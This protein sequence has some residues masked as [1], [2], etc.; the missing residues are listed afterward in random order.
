MKSDYEFRA[1]KS[2]M[3]SGSGR[4]R[5][6]VAVGHEGRKG[7]LSVVARVPLS[8]ASCISRKPWRNADPKQPA[9]YLVCCPSYHSCGGS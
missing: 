2:R 8:S 5:P 3:W 4:L 6:H 9:E 1:L 7:D